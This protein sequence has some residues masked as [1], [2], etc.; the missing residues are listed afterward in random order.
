MSDSIEK[1]A[2]M[3]VEFMQELRLH[4]EDI[5]TLRKEDIATL[6]KEML[7]VKDICRSCAGFQQDDFK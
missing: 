6:R 4:K 2:L 3:L 7:Q 5:A 1:L